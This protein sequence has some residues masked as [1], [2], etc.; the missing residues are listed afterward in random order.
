MK[1]P[2]TKQQ[3]HDITALSNELDRRGVSHVVV[4]ANAVKPSKKL[5]RLLLRSVHVLRNHVFLNQLAHW[6]VRGN[7]FQEQHKFFQEQYEQYFSVMD[8]VAEHIKK[9]NPSYVISGFGETPNP[10]YIVEPGSVLRA[11]GYIPR[12]LENLERLG[13]LARVIGR[14]G[15]ANHDFPTQDLAGKLGEAYAKSTWMLDAMQDSETSNT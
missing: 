6:N 7:T 3:L 8:D 13:K 4:T 10:D 5:I 1:T 11:R 9:L 15:E 2:R 12:M 14:I